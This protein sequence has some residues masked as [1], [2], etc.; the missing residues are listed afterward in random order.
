[1]SLVPRAEE[2]PRS[3]LY[4]DFFAAPDS[5][6]YHYR[7]PNPDASGLHTV[8]N[9]ALRV[10]VAP[11]RIAERLAYWGVALPLPGLLKFDSRLW[12]AA[13]RVCGLAVPQPP[14]GFVRVPTD[15]NTHTMSACNGRVAGACGRPE[16]G[17]VFSVALNCAGLSLLCQPPEPMRPTEPTVAAAIASKKRT[18][19]AAAAAEAAAAATS[20][21]CWSCA[22]VAAH[23]GVDIAQHECVRDRRVLRQDAS[24]TPCVHHCPVSSDCVTND[25]QKA[26]LYVQCT[27]YWLSIRQQWFLDPH[28]HTYVAAFDPHSVVAAPNDVYVFVA[29]ALGF[30]LRPECART[31]DTPRLAVEK[32]RSALRADGTMDAVKL[33][34]VA[35]RYLS[36][37]SFIAFVSER[38]YMCGIPVDRPDHPM[39]EVIGD[40]TVAPWIDPTFPRAP[41]APG[42][43]YQTSGRWECYSK[44]SATGRLSGM[45][46]AARGWMPCE[47]PAHI[48][49]MM[50][51][52]STG[53]A[54]KSMAT[55]CGLFML[56][57][58]NVLRD[59]RAH[60]YMR[61]L[62]LTPN[63][64][65]LLFDAPALGAR[66]RPVTTASPPAFATLGEAAVFMHASL[67]VY[68]SASAKG[69]TDT[70]GANTPGGKAARGQS[71]K[72]PSRKK[73]AAAATNHRRA[74]QR[75]ARVRRAVEQEPRYMDDEVDIDDD[76]EYL[77]GSPWHSGGDDDADDNRSRP[78]ASASGGAV[79]PTTAD[80]DD[81]RE[82]ED[83]DSDA[84]EGGAA[85]AGSA[86]PPPPM[87]PGQMREAAARALAEARIR[88]SDEERA[89]SEA[90]WR[91][92]T[93]ST[94]RP[95]RV[96]PFWTNLTI[97]RWR[98]CRVEQA[99]VTSALLPGQ[100][101]RAASTPLEE[102]LEWN[103]FHPLMQQPVRLCN[104]WLEAGLFT[105]QSAALQEMDRAQLQGAVG[106]DVRG[107]ATRTVPLPEQARRVHTLLWDAVAEERRR[108]GALMDARC[109]FLG[110]AQDPSAIA[111]VLGTGLRAGLPADVLWYLVLYYAWLDAMAPLWMTLG[112]RS[113]SRAPVPVP[114]FAA[115]AAPLPSPQQQPPQPAQRQQQQQTP[116]SRCHSNSG[117]SLEARA[118]AAAAEAV[119]ARATAATAPKPSVVV[120]DDDDDDDAPEVPLTPTPTGACVVL[121]P[122][123]GTRANGSFF[124]DGV[125]RNLPAEATG[126]G[127]WPSVVAPLLRRLA[128]HWN[129]GFIDRSKTLGNVVH[130]PTATRSA[131]ERF[132]SEALGDTL[133]SFGAFAIEKTHPDVF[134]VHDS[135]QFSPS[136]C[137]LV[138]A[139]V[140]RYVTRPAV[141]AHVLARHRVTLVRGTD[142][143]VPPPPPPPPPPAVA[144]VAV[145]SAVEAARKR[146]AVTLLGCNG[147]S[148]AS[149]AGGARRAPQSPEE[150]RAAA[151][152]AHYAA[153]AAQ[154]AALLHACEQEDPEAFT[155]SRLRQ[156]A[157]DAVASASGAHEAAVRAT[158]AADA[159][160][161]APSS[162]A[163]A[164]VAAAAAAVAPAP[165][166]GDDDDDD[167]DDDGTAAETPLGLHTAMWTFGDYH[168]RHGSDPVPIA[169]VAHWFAAGVVQPIVRLVM[170]L[171]NAPAAA[172]PPPGCTTVATSAASG[173]MFMVQLPTWESRWF[174][175]L[176][177]EAMRA[178]G[179]AM[180]RAA[181][182]LMQQLCMDPERDR[183][184][185]DRFL[186]DSAESDNHDVRAAS[187]G[188]ALFVA[189]SDRPQPLPPAQAA[190]ATVAATRR[191]TH[192]LTDEEKKAEA[193][194]R[195]MS[196]MC[197]SLG[198]DC[199]GEDAAAAAAAAVD[200]D[201]DATTGKR[202]KR[203]RKRKP[204]AAD[205][206]AAGTAK[207]RADRDGA[208]LRAKWTPAL[209]SFRQRKLLSFGEPRRLTFAPHSW[210]A[211]QQAATV[212]R[213]V[214]MD[215]RTV[216]DAIDWMS[217][218]SIQLANPAARTASPPRIE[219]LQAL[220]RGLGF[221]PSITCELRLDDAVR[222]LH[223]CA[224]ALLDTGLGAPPCADEHDRWRRHYDTAMR[225]RDAID[226]VRREPGIPEAAKALLLTA[227]AVCARDCFVAPPAPLVPEF[228]TRLERLQARRITVA[229]QRRCARQLEELAVL[230]GEIEKARLEARA[231]RQ[232]APPMLSMADA[233][234]AAAKAKATQNVLYPRRADG[235][236]R[237]PL[238]FAAV[239]VL[240]DVRTVRNPE[241]VAVTY[242]VKY[243][244]RDEAWLRQARQAVAPQPPPPP[245]PVA[246]VVA[247]AAPVPLPVAP[248]A[249]APAPMLC[250]IPSAVPTAAGAA[251]AAAADRVDKLQ[252]L[253]N[254]F[255]SARAA[256]VAQDSEAR[257]RVL[258]PPPPPRPPAVV[259]AAQP[260]KAPV[261]SFDPSYLPSTE[262]PLLS[263]QPW[264]QTK[265]GGMESFVSQ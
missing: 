42:R 240:E 133:A 106:A 197:A 225:I 163:T 110:A 119:I 85:A 25:Q 53:P 48:Q 150:L 65:V 59:K 263:K 77:P 149:S 116:F 256:V 143:I 147:N 23:E 137:A 171:F 107:P 258:M 24:R 78:A 118:A 145:D 125:G 231:A 97:C 232:A 84:E 123:Q 221:T 99:T 17:G 41:L 167:D 192:A 70:A 253:Q 126:F 178:C 246:A 194:A 219:A 95:P 32:A 66:V 71:K 45:F 2:M 62:Y 250:I 165:M 168:V 190:G 88:A 227:I 200:G 104:A 138:R 262:L 152:T 121:P 203:T 193:E 46:F 255:D 169:R 238:L 237:A 261:A 80:P 216:Q 28:T 43:L 51:D 191:I 40:G 181:E 61:H 187:L 260:P 6:V 94:I 27:Q 87:R 185:A 63:E 68:Q 243:G 127:P 73:I 117:T 239:M 164:A 199:V 18:A 111:W 98:R 4:A 153:F 195:Q 157:N 57:W 196:E 142:T 13:P 128:E 156:F 230:D 223:Q 141:V 21:R 92:L 174:I 30:R 224:G 180:R 132:V 236:D 228:E 52:T 9:H 202:R 204:A 83:D 213:S 257:A 265:T 245:R 160:P 100:Y 252:R 175:P 67:A 211:V 103:A 129:A 29:A 33:D 201:D 254:V 139:V 39:Y 217:W 186:D 74:V 14:E 207:A 58:A 102:L 189:P 210:P 241:G 259:A 209:S 19:A 234:A 55:L 235:T 31:P 56:N 134:S 172:V 108:T 205:R 173:R 96:A 69:A 222:G 49:R 229:Q 10:P 161:V 218:A 5:A 162:V 105:P 37:R 64:S 151:S 140:E 130:A 3:A 76:D 220:M 144:V 120:M 214:H 198:L 101:P 109:N 251:A 15:Q 113:V 136:M 215:I 124:P 20:N 244:A 208:A 93:T 34:E 170:A 158:T 7:V 159:A 183:M 90:L 226:T 131:L 50:Y 154:L 122:S 242:H 177:E 233:E 247:T 115:T 36:L 11:T 38:L 166:K 44:M 114:L 75:A 91:A 184:K 146:R 1:M 72:A 8:D 179:A 148:S 155:A 188:L 82:F 12:D 22:S 47:I 112:R 264:L 206:P 81:T 89:V 135:R 248:A 249:A 35:A 54:K 176:E 86:A 79:Q 60:W 182:K 16:G 26:F 212:D